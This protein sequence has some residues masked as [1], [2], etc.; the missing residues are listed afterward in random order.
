MNPADP[1]AKVALVIVPAAGV[2]F[3]DLSVDEHLLVAA[4]PGRFTPLQ[5]YSVFP[6]L[7]PYRRRAYAALPRAERRMLALGQALAEFRCLG[8]QLLVAELGKLR[9]E[10]VDLRHRLVEAFDDTIIG[11][12]EQASGQRPQHENLDILMT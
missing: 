1:K 9:F 12:A 4:R 5:I 10:C 3:R 2:V 6:N 7:R 11:C 8:A